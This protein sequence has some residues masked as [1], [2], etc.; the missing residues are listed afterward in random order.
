[1]ER[2]ESHYKVDMSEPR[3][4]LLTEPTCGQW[5]RTLLSTPYEST[6]LDEFLTAPCEALCLGDGEGADHDERV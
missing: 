2:G 1:M 6:E 5:R 3:I 4:E